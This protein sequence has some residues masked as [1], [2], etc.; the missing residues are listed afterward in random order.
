MEVRSRDKIWLNVRHEDQEGWM[1]QDLL[2]LDDDAAEVPE[3]GGPPPFL[4]T[5][6]AAFFSGGYADAL[7]ALDRE[8]LGDQRV[9]KHVHL[10]RAA[11]HYA[12][13]QL[14]DGRDGDRRRRPLR[15]RGPRRRGLQPGFRPF[16]QLG[17]RVAHQAPL[18]SLAAEGRPPWIVPA[19]KSV[20][21]SRSCGR[22]R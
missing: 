10:F 8:D 15:R 16:L 17:R 1:H 2:Q 20:A 22:A 4:R 14:Q 12:L 13:H 6:A 9:Q 18:G 7:S 11:S 3:D 5:A 19:A 21:L